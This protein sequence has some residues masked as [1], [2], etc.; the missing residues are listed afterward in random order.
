MILKIG[1]IK[2]LKQLKLCLKN[3]RKIVNKNKNEK[4]N[5]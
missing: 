4:K 3:K 2:H 1:L 5:K